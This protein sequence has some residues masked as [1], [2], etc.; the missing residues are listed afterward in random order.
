MNK[1]LQQD[2]VHIERMNTDSIGE[3]IQGTEAEFCKQE[4]RWQHQQNLDVDTEKQAAM[5]TH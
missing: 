5:H 1:E 2:L 4:T 3:K